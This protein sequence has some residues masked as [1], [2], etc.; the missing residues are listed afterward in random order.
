MIEKTEIR[1]LAGRGLYG[2]YAI[3]R[4]DEALMN[5]ETVLTPL[6]QMSSLEF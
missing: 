3:K 2:G 5:V 4:Q 6:V 1:I